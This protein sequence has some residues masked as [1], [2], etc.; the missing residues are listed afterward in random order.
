MK[1]L[2]KIL[3]GMLALL[4]VL[5]GGA[6]AWVHTQYEARASA[7]HDVAPFEIKSLVASADVA[8]GRRIYE[9]RGGCVDCHGPDLAGQRVMD[10][11]AMG[12]I[13]GANVIPHALKDWTDEEIARAIRYGVHRTGRALRFMP[14]FDY[15]S[16]SLGDVAALVAFLRS[17]APVERASVPVEIGPVAKGLFVFGKMPVLLAAHHLDLKKGFANKPEEGPTVAFGQ[18]LAQA[19]TGCHGVE[20][21]G[22]PIVGGDPSWPEAASARLGSGAWTEEA[23]STMIRTGVSPTT[24]QKLRPPMPV[25]LLAQMNEVEIKALWS[26]LS[27]LK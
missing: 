20:F 26:F 1:K 2:F 24:R 17:A 13:H 22:G 9:V 27:T 11:G 4:L 7:T 23:F 8:L 6:A 3:G 16:L 10:N 18:Y 15:E 21:R 25:H 19:C 12:R 14:A 5:V